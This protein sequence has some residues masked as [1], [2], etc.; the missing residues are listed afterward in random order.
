MVT[1]C[2]FCTSVYVIVCICNLKVDLTVAYNLMCVLLKTL[3]EPYN[4]NVF[5]NL[6]KV[7]VQ[8]NRNNNYIIFVHSFLL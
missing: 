4:R 2:Y 8:N 6:Y 1:P 3:Q 7:Y 5:T